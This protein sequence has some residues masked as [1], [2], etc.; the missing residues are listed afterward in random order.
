M[1]SHVPLLCHA[2]EML[3]KLEPAEAREPSMSQGHPESTCG[4][5]GPSAM[6]FMFFCMKK[7]HI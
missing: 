4:F 2:S 1:A 7:N 5:V 6:F 3:P